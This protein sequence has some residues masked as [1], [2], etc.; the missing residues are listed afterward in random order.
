MTLCVFVL[1]ASEFMPVS[2]LT[3]IARDLDVTE[4]LADRNCHLRRAGRPD[5]PDAF[6]VG[7]KCE[8]QVLTAGDDD[9]DG[10]VGSL[11]HWLPTI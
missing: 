3:P 11:S 7:W 5:Q 10:R 8:S 1:I 9:S 2:L 6:D 4:G